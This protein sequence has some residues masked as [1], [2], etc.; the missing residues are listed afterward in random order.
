MEFRWTLYKNEGLVLLVKYEGFPRQYILYRK[1]D[2]DCVKI[3]L[4]KKPPKAWLYSYLLIK[5]DDFD[6]KRYRAVLKIFI[7]SPLKEY[8]VSFIEPK[9]K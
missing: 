5:F 9:R 2:M 8:E 1:N 3:S 4:G 6:E 7:K